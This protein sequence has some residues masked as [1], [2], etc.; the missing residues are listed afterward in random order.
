VTVERAMQK[1]L[2][3]PVAPAWRF[4]LPV[5]ATLFRIPVLMTA[6]ALVRPAFGI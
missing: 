5:I 1:W 3:L 2:C 6:L 4:L